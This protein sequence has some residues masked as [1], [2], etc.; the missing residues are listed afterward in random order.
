[1]CTKKVGGVKDRDVSLVTES[2][3]PL[4]K[5]HVTFVQEIESAG[6]DGLSNRLKSYTMCPNQDGA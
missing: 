1:M 2:V 3:L 5:E 6:E 4:R